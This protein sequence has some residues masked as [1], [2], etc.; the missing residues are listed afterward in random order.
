MVQSSETRRRTFAVG[1]FDRKV[2]ELRCVRRPQAP[3]PGPWRLTAIVGDRSA[4]SAPG[5]GES[6]VVIPFPGVAAESS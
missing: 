3:F 1:R 4:P 2:A 6:P 5:S